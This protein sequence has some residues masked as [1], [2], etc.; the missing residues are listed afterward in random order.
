M[1]NSRVET[2]IMKDMKSYNYSVFDK[3]LINVYNECLSWYND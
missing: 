1:K 3:T 2:D